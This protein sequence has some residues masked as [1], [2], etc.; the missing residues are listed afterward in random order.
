MIPHELHIGEV[1]LPPLLVA[2]T[3]AL[4][5]TWLT[6]IALNRLRWSRYFAAPNLVFLAIMTIYTVLIGTY[7]VPI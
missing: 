3:L 4:I 6:T 5:L 7:V 2:F 1:Y